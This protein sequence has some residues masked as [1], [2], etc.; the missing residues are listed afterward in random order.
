MHAQFPTLIPRI[1]EHLA[2]ENDEDALLSQEEA[3]LEAQW[4]A[5]RQAQAHLMHP[6]KHNSQAHHQEPEQDE[7]DDE[8]IEEE[9]EG[10]DF[11]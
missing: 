4:A 2:T 6:G 7:V 3:K 9:S 11:E 5:I 1:T 10:D 8:E